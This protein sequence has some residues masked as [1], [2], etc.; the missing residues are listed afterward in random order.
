[1]RRIGSL[2]LGPLVRQP[3]TT[4]AGSPVLP[5]RIERS[6]D[7]LLDAGRKLLQR[8]ASR[9]TTSE[10]QRVELFHRAV[11]LFRSA[12]QDEQS[13]FYLRVASDG[14]RRDELL[15]RSEKMIAEAAADET[16]DKRRARLY[17]DAVKVLERVEKG[18]PWDEA[19]RRG[20]DRA[21]RGVDLEQLISDGVR[22]LRAPPPP[23]DTPGPRAAAAA[24]A[25]GDSGE[26]GA[27]AVA[28]R[29]Q[30]RQAAHWLMTAKQLD[31]TS[32]HAAR[33]LTELCKE[34]GMAIDHDT[35][36]RWEEPAV[37][38]Q[39]DDAAAARL[40]KRRRRVALAEI[41]ARHYPAGTEDTAHSGGPLRLYWSEQTEPA[42][43]QREWAL[44]SLL[45]KGELRATPRSREGRT[46]AY[47]GLDALCSLVR[48][49]DA[50][51]I[52]CGD[53]WLRLLDH[54]GGGSLSAAT[55]SAANAGQ[56]RGQSG[57]RG[58]SRAAAAS[59]SSSAAAAAAAPRK[60][61][62]RRRRM[63]GRESAVLDV[64]AARGAPA[65]VDVEWLAESL[66]RR[67]VRL[68]PSEPVV[69]NVYDLGTNEG[70]GQLSPPPPPCPP[71]CTAPGWLGA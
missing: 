19:C 21:K 32:S 42:L 8:A 57:G 53:V 25:A 55:L 44:L 24:A 35:L 54:G 28:R 45:R 56:S 6:Q 63:A 48:S 71:F 17:K 58:A 52:K 30:L 34:L 40:F 43:A 62:E 3:D 47:A 64:G 50:Q 20:L 41:T 66:L 46:F 38:K 15:L 61:G 16:S 10:E 68:L 2:A 18:R 49:R 60:P 59:S 31:P 1:M 26:G 23:T 39:L 65:T 36:R 11:A 29:E 69:L 22:L 7:E 9:S 14:L 27:G 12:P 37:Q 5:P 33:H 51:L 13:L 67:V 4:M 70:C